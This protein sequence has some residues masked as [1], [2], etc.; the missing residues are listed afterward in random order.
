MRYKKIFLIGMMYSGKTTIG[1]ILSKKIK[2]SFLDID[3]ELQDILDMSVNEIFKVHGEKKFRK[4]ET[5]FFQE[6]SKLN[7]YIFSTSGGIILNIDNQQILKNHSAV[8][9]LDS[10][11][12]VI[13]DRFQKDNNKHQRPLLENASISLINTLCENRYDLYKSCSKFIINTDSCSPHE[14]ATKIENY[15]NA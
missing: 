8:F 14:A 12:E 7:K 2:L 13:Y 1:K 4:L 15:L 11:P 9:F 5:V 6:C 10:S 3:L